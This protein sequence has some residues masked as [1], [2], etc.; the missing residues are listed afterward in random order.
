MDKVVQGRG[1]DS[2]KPY[3]KSHRNRDRI[4]EA[5]FI[6]HANKPPT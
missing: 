1:C 5:I 4:I 2:C 6:A 3:T